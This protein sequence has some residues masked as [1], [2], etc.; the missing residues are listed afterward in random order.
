[1]AHERAGSNPKFP[2]FHRKAIDMA[3]EELG[4]KRDEFSKAVL[5]NNEFPEKV[6]EKFEEQCSTEKD[7][8][9]R[10]TKKKSTIKTN[11]KLTAGPVKGIL[12]LLRKEGEANIVMLLGRK[13]I[14]DARKLL[15]EQTKTR[16]RNGD[17]VCG[18]IGDK[19]S[20]FIMRDFHAFFGLWKGN[21]KENY[22]NYLYLQPVD[23]W[24]RK[25][26]EIIWDEELKNSH[27]RAAE[28]IVR[29]CKEED[30]NPVCY[31][32]GAWFVGAKI[33]TFY[34]PPTTEKKYDKKETLEKILN[35]VTVERK[36]KE[37]KP[38]VDS[39]CSYG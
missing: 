7:K 27:D 16:I 28:E 1:M 38:L 30:I 32:Q 34:G 33:W 17:E 23:R 3:L 35:I 37:I 22:H 31:N 39:I 10:K 2:S 21:L 9:R 12:E 8:E 11:K 19:L 6:W 18:G 4:Y 13:K 36:M 14:R 24:V 29:R 5:Y 15:K 20:T 25:I 26:S